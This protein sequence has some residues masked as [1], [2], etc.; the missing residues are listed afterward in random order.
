MILYKIYKDNEDFYVKYENYNAI[1]IDKTKDI[2]MDYKGFMGVPI[3]FMHKY[4]PEQFEIIGLGISS[5]GI[6]IGVSPYKE[7][8]KIYRKKIQKRAAVDGDLYMIKNG[9]V[10]VPYARVIIKK[11]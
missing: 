3:T 7:E 1:N 2:P 11:K 8:H 10:E 6:E 9:V 5:S 4:N